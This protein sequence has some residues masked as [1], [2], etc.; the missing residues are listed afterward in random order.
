MRVIP[1]IDVLDGA[2]VRLVQGRYDEVTRYGNDP[3]EVARRWRDAGAPLVHV[4]DLG[5]A[6]SG[7]PDAALWDAMAT[8]GVGFQVGGGIRRTEDA[9]AA[10]AAGAARVVVG[11]VAVWTPAAVEEMIAAVGVDRVVAA[12][13][14]REERATGSGWRDSGVPV[15]ALAAELAATGVRRALVTGIARDG[16]MSGPDLGLI[17]LVAGAAPEMALIGSGGV[18]SVDDLLTL[19]EAGVEAAVVGRALY[20]GRFTY[21]E[22]IRAL[23]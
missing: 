22:A 7:V 17:H 3:V 5:A 6:R 20:E 10:V 13:D 19:Q 14:V 18:G 9:V 23:A 4:V 2:V 11:S 21:G 8:V 15:A 1:A 16:V 12:L